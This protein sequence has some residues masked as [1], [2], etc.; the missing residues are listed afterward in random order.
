MPSIA[1]LKLD[2]R[3][4]RKRGQRAEGML[5]ASLQEVGAARSIVI[6][7]TNRVLAGNGT[8]A[9]AAEAGIERVKVVD[10]DGETIVAVR[11]SGLSEKQKARLAL[12]DNRTAE[13]AEW[14]AEMLASL[15]EDGVELDD[16][17]SADELTAVLNKVAEPLPPEHF[18]ELDEN[19]ET[20]YC[21]PKCG[22]K[23]SGN[24][25]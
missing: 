6:D 8:V 7:E 3:N 19:A 17:W 12:L 23:W 4:A 11:R 21:C 9:A 22:Y 16:L 25:E 18:P 10:A 2:K 24:P 14:D 13:L 1:D 15:A 5:V 20:T